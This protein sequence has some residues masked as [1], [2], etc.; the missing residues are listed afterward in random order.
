LGS[1]DAVFIRDV[2]GVRSDC[3]IWPSGVV[4]KLEGS[5][6]RVPKPGST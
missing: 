3:F 2:V 6:H 1:L 5:I 4:L